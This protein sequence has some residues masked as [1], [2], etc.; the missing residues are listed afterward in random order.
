MFL[1]GQNIHSVSLGYIHPGDQRKRANDA[2]FILDYQ[3]MHQYR[4]GRVTWLQESSTQA[5]V[6]KSFTSKYNE[7]LHSFI[8]KFSTRICIFGLLVSVCKL[9]ATK[10]A[11]V[12]ATLCIGRGYPTFTSLVLSTAK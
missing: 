2:A 5:A 1:V 7:R 4:V 10:L 9:T 12:E 3:A 6:L 8:Y 11:I